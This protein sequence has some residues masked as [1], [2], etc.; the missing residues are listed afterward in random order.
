MRLAK[1]TPAPQTVAPKKLGVLP[2]LNKEWETVGTIYR[3]SNYSIFSHIEGNRNIEPHNVKRLVAS[4]SEKYIPVPIVCNEKLQIIDGQNRAE[5]AMLLGF[6][7]YYIVVPDL[8]KEDVIRLNVNRSNW[9]TETYLKAFVSDGLEDYI[10]FK[11]F[12]KKYGFGYME[13]LGILM[14]YKSKANTDDLREFQA[15]NFKVKDYKRA[16]WIGEKIMTVKPYFEFATNRTFVYAMLHVLD[17]PNYDHAEF[18]AKLS[19]QQTRLV[20]C[21]SKDQYVQLIEEIYNYKRRD[22]VSLRY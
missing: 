4:M 2:P 16:V 3:T 14:G 15:G 22:K 6:P 13:C 17:H 9:S 18:L 7:I 12:K 19:F 10:I 8:R 5:A 11:E 1:L 20:R 21:A